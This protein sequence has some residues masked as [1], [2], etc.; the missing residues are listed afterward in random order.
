MHGDVRKPQPSYG[1]EHRRVIFSGGNV[2]HGELSDRVEGAADDFAEI[3]VDGYGNVG[4]FFPE[5]GQRPLKPS[6]FLFD[7]DG[8]T[9]RSCRTG[10]DVKDTG[11]V[12]DHLFRPVEKGVHVHVTFG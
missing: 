4:E 2:V 1:G 5:K 6:P 3:S 8:V 10:S 7:P 11:S 9:S 12:L